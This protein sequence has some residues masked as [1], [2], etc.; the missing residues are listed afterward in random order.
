MGKVQT[1]KTILHVAPSDSEELSFRLNADH[2]AG[3]ED[4]H[5]SIAVVWRYRPRVR[6]LLHSSVIVCG[7][8][9]KRNKLEIRLH[10]S[11]AGLGHWNYEHRIISSGI[12]LFICFGV[13]LVCPSITNVQFFHSSFATLYL[14]PWIAERRCARAHWLAIR[15]PVGSFIAVAS[16]TPA[17]M[18]WVPPIVHLPVV[19]LAIPLT[20][21]AAYSYQ[22]FK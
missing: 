4:L 12:I 1:D 14:I 5:P 17:S 6:M 7:Q 21:L 8:R 19:S 10:R 22:N 15:T 3:V 20:S 18:S 13:G 9:N 2:G 11:S 16:S